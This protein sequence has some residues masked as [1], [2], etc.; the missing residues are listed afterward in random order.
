MYLNRAVPERTP[1]RAFQDFAAALSFQV[2]TAL[3]D[4]GQ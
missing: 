2:E 1:E 3:G 4:V